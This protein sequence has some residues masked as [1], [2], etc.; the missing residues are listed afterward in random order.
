MSR[1]FSRAAQ[2][3]TFM[4]R[5]ARV[6]RVTF[7]EDG[8]RPET[9]SDHTVMLAVMACDFAPPELNRGRIAEFAIV[10]DLVEGY[11]GD[12]QTLTIDAAGKAAKADREHEALNRILSE[13]GADSWIGVTLLAYEAQVEPEAIYVRV[14]D[15]VMPK[16][17]HLFNGCVAAKRLTDLAGFRA[18]HERQI[19]DMTEQYGGAAYA[20]HAQALLFEAMRA[21]EAAWSEG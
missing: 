13:F 10:H 21:S 1:Q 14:M 6:E 15:K 2:I 16:L 4:L 3:A 9:D 20:S 8:V 17:T 18:A 11:A 5:F 7:H 19:R 12:A